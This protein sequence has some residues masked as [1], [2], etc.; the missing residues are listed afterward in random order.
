M[1]FFV[2]VAI[3]KFIVLSI[4]LFLVFEHLSISYLALLI[5]I[6]LA[7]SIVFLKLIGMG[8]VNFMNRTNQIENKEISNT[9]L[10]VTN[11]KQY[12]I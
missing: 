6:G 12:S 1:P 10:Q 3:L 2:I 7:Q 9:K 11:K 8:L 5:G 4:A